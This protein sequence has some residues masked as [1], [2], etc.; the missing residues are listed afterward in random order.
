MSETTNTRRM[1]HEWPGL[2]DR[3]AA[4]LP[5]DFER[6]RPFPEEA[7]MTVIHDANTLTTNPLADN[8]YFGYGNSMTGINDVL[9]TTDGRRRV[10]D[11]LH[12]ALRMN[13]ITPA[14]L[15]DP[16]NPTAAGDILQ[17]GIGVFGQL[18]RPAIKAL[19][20]AEHLVTEAL[21]L[22]TER[23][24]LW[25][26]VLDDKGIIPPGLVKR[27]QL[28]EGAAVVIGANSIAGPIEILRR[29]LRAKQSV[30]PA[31]RLHDVSPKA[32]LK[33]SARAASLHSEELQD[34][35]FVDK[36]VAANDEGDL[37]F[38][39]TDFPREPQLPRPGGPRTRLEHTKR[40]TC[41]ALQIGQ[42]TLI[43]TTVE[44]VWEAL[45]R[46]EE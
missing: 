22:V 32:L 18:A 1:P 25:G 33:I 3:A 20:A 6:P 45:V 15:F 40:E 16:R 14:T 27:A 46:T 12:R 19:P 23:R 36:L 2:V 29:A 42:L 11:E 39:N 31:A 5:A 10:V 21:A 24:R 4:L 38:N 44:V 28:G 37:Y 43:G 30:N 41:P 35:A 26:G 17:I 7:T 8:L 9:Q 34:A 13:R